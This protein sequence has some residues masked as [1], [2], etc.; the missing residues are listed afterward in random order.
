MLDSN[1]AATAEHEARRAVITLNPLVHEIEP[2]VFV[3]RH[4]LV[5]TTPVSVDAA[6]VLQGATYVPMTDLVHDGDRRD[7]LSGLLSSA[8]VALYEGRPEHPDFRTAEDVIAV[9]RSLS[10]GPAVTADFVPYLTLAPHDMG[11]FGP[12]SRSLALAHDA[13][14]PG[15]RSAVIAVLDTGLPANWKA[16]HPGN[17]VVADLVAADPTPD[18]LYTA[19][20]NLDEPRAVG[21]GLFVATIAGR[22]TPQS[23]EVRVYRC[24]EFFPYEP[25]TTL[26]SAADIAGDLAL[27]Q[28]YGRADRPL[29]V[30]MS[31]G[32]Y[33]ANNMQIDLLGLLL[34][35]ILLS[36]P[37]TVFCC[38]AGN[39]ANFDP[40]PGDPGYNDGTKPIHPAAYS[41]D[42]DLANNVVAV[43]ALDVG[44][45]V[46]PFSG[47]GPWVNAW[48]LGVD[49]VSEYV[50]GT[51]I[52]T[53]K[54][55]LPQ[56]VATFPLIAPAAAWSGTSFASPQVAAAIARECV[57]TGR[58]PQTVWAAMRR[59]LQRDPAWTDKDGANHVEVGVIVP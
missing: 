32:G 24:S 10:S 23:V 51:W 36:D 21:H 56:I 13:R 26:L 57:A 4:R 33:Y 31:F 35:A 49:V 2:E 53:Q 59:T 34:K 44:G 55:P 43:G 15:M 45:N 54:A 7:A 25:L 18:P 9:L 19:P 46:A 17:P 39:K 12:P 1:P 28:R 30:N 40:P 38:A 48:A 20:L 22:S 3:A 14:P 41:L 58:S 29:I 37:G 50:P 47:R 52:T 5:L 11:P 8:G 42:V 16:F 27:A 6:A